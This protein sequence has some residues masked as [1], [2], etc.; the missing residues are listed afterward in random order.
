MRVTRVGQDSTLAAMS[1]LLERARSLAPAHCRSAPIASPAWFVG[2]VL[3]LAAL[4]GRS[5]GCASMRRVPFRPCWRCWWSPARARCRW[6][7]PAALAAATTRLARSG[8]LVTRGRALERLASAD[9]IVFD[10]TGTL[11]RGQPRIDRVRTAE[12][13]HRAVSAAWRSPRHSSAIPRIRSRMPSRCS[14]RLVTS[15]GWRSTAGT[16]CGGGST[17]SAIASAAPDYALEIC[18]PA[19]RRMPA[20]ADETHT[21]IVL[22]DRV[23]ACW[24]RSDLTDSLRDDA[25]ET[26]SGCRG[27]VSRR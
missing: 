1:R 3:L 21:S 26:V 9:R 5:T 25:R 16:R 14:I 7:R 6:P 20:V 23:R 13:A 4:V 19:L 12:R 27:S 11:T 10:K 24:R 2:A 15:T 18:P 17:V 22:G 8:L